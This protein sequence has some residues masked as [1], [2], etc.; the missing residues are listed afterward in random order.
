MKK[1]LVL[2]FILLF[3]VTVNIAQEVE[4]KRY[5]RVKKI[6]AFVLPEVPKDY[7]NLISGKFE[8]PARD[9]HKYTLFFQNENGQV[10]MIRVIFY[11]ATGYIPEIIISEFPRKP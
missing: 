2:L 1:A 8:M 6:R 7:G 10:T 11:P 5:S 3:M 4:P 9:E